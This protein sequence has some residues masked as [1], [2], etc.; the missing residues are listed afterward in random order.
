MVY[1]IICGFLFFQYLFKIFCPVTPHYFYRDL[2][3]LITSYWTWYYGLAF[4]TNHKKKNKVYKLGEVHDRISILQL[5]KSK[6]SEKVKTKSRYESR[7]IIVKLE[8]GSISKIR[9]KNSR[10]I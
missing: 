6:N 4:I 2:L 5:P 3:A 10:N 1:C 9:L 7:K 8:L